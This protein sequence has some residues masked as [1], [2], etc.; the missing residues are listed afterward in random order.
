M[1]EINNFTL[2]SDFEMGIVDM[3]T[4]EFIS[5]IGIIGGTKAEP[6]S[7]GR[8]CFR[9]EDN[10]NF[11]ANIPPVR[12]AID[13]SNYI[14]YCIDTVNEE[15]L[16]PQGLQ[17]RAYTSAIYSDEQLASPKARQF[18]CSVTYNA[19]TGKPMEKP[20]GEGTNLRSAG[21]HV[22][23]GFDLE[24]GE[25]FTD[26]DLWRFIKTMDL[27]LGVPSILIDKDTTRR[28]LYGK[29]GEYRVKTKYNIINNSI[30]IIPE[31]RSLGSN[32]LAT[33]E[34]IQWVFTQTVKAIS[35]YN[36]NVELPGSIVE[37]CINNHLVETAKELCKEYSLEYPKI[38][39]NISNKINSVT[40]KESCPC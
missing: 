12:N 18:G 31:Y 8:D 37:R 33:S 38:E 28:Q 11:E 23:V 4:Q 34:T 26:E 14:K 5:G 36:D 40:Y 19:Y 35:A 25:K 27:Y 9:Q 13:W 16:N 10:I 7:I 15:I 20:K 21:F 17:L 30:L 32:L 2:G 24:E 29:A 39:I 22:H 6:L 1:K 3:D